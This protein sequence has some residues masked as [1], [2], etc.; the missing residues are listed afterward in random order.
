[1]NPEDD[2]GTWSEILLSCIEMNAQLHDVLPS[3]NRLLE[4]ILTTGYLN[5][6]ITES[7]EYF[8]KTVLKTAIH[9]LLG[10]DV[11]DYDAKGDIQQ[12][13]LNFT[14]LFTWAAIQGDLDLV[15]SAQQ[16]F[17]PKCNI[18]RTKNYY[19]AY[20]MDAK[21]MMQAWA[22]SDDPVNLVIHASSLKGADLLNVLDIIYRTYYGFAFYINID[23][24][25]MLGTVPSLK[26]YIASLTDD[27]LN[28]I[29]LSKLWIVV[30]N[31]VQALYELDCEGA[32]ITGLLLDFGERLVESDIRRRQ[33]IGGQI[34][35]LVYTN[36]LSDTLAV[37]QEWK[38]RTKLGTVLIEMEMHPQLLEAVDKFLPDLLDEKTLG[39]FMEKAENSHTSEKARMFGIAS[40]AMVNLSSDAMKAFVDKIRAKE[41]ISKEMI[42]FLASSLSFVSSKRSEIVDDILDTLIEFSKDKQKEDAVLA[43]F[44][45]IGEGRSTVV[46]K[47]AIAK[48][49]E[50]LNNKETTLF[51]ASALWATLRY[52]FCTDLGI[53]LPDVVATAIRDTKASGQAR[54]AQFQLM[55]M[56]VQKSYEAVPPKVIQTIVESGSDDAVWMF[57]GKLL[58]HSGTDAL[59]SGTTKIIVQQI[60]ANGLANATVPF[61]EFLKTFILTLNLRKGFLQNTYGQTTYKQKVVTTQFEITQWPIRNSTLLSDCVVKCESAEVY[62]KAKEALVFMCSKVRSSERPAV[63]E[64]FIQAF[65]DAASVGDN[66]KARVLSTLIAYIDKIEEKVHLEDFG[67]FRHKSQRTTGLWTLHIECQAEGI[68]Y[69][70]Q[71]DPKSS[72]YSLKERICSK[73]GYLPSNVT[74]M[75]DRWSISQYHTLELAYVRN[76]SVISVS[77]IRHCERAP[78]II[79]SLV[80]HERGFTSEVYKELETTK[81]QALYKECKR[82]LNRLPSNPKVIESLDDMESVIERMRTSSDY[83]FEYYLR[84]LLASLREDSVYGEKFHE[85]GGCPVLIQYLLNHSTEPKL[86]DQV[87]IAVETLFCDDMV[88]KAEDVIPVL[89]GLFPLMKESVVILSHILRLFG[90]HDALTTTSVTMKHFEP[91]AKAIEC[92]TRE[93]YSHFYYYMQSIHEKYQ[94]SLLCLKH[95]KSSHQQERNYFHSLFVS[96]IMAVTDEEQLKDILLECIESLPQ[97][98]GLVLGS[99]CHVVSSLVSTHASLQQQCHGIGKAILPSIF[100]TSDRKVRVEVCNLCTELDVW[101]DEDCV[102]FMRGALDVSIDRWNYDPSKKKVSVPGYVGLRNLG[103]TCY[104]NSVLQQLFYTY[105]FRYL[106]VTTEVTDESQIELKRIFTELLLSTRYYCD[107]KPFCNVWKGWMKRPINPREQQDAN[108]FFQLLLD[109]LPAD[110]HSMFKGEIENRIEGTDEEFVSTNLETFYSIGLDIKDLSSVT[111]SFGSFVQNEYFTGENQYSIGDRKINARK[112]ARIKTAPNVLVLQL[113]RFEYD[114]TTFSRRK[115]DDKYEFE[116]EFNLQ[117]YMVDTSQPQIY[118]LSGVV[119]HSGNAEGGHYCSYVLIGNEWLCFDDS[120]VSVVS[121]YDF[122]DDTYGGSDYYNKDSLPGSAYLLFYRKKDA[123]VQ[124][125]GQTLSFTSPP[126]LSGKCNPVMAREIEDANMEFTKHQALF[127]AK[128]ASFVCGSDD[129]VVLLEYFFNVFCHS[130]LETRAETISGHLMNLF[131]N[132]DVMTVFNFVLD[133]YVSIE[134]IFRY[135]GSPGILRVFHG[136]IDK[137]LELVDTENGFKLLEKFVDM[138]PPLVTANWKQ[139]PN[140]TERLYAAFVAQPAYVQLASQNQWDT[141]LCQL[142][143]Q[144]YD[145]QKSSVVL[146]NI[147]LSTVFKCLCLVIENS[148]SK[149]TLSLAPYYQQIFQSKLHVEA[150][151]SLLKLLHKGNILELAEPLDLLMSIESYQ[152]MACDLLLNAFASKSAD[153]SVI[154]LL[155]KVFQRNYESSLANFLTKS[156]VLVTNGALS[157]EVINSLIECRGDLIF[158]FLSDE[159]IQLAKA[160]ESLALSLIPN[161]PPA[162]LDSSVEILK[163]V[164]SDTEEYSSYRMMVID[165]TRYVS[166]LRV[167]EASIRAIEHIDEDVFKVIMDFGTLV[168]E[169]RTSCDDS[170]L[171]QCVSTVCSVPPSLL[172]PKFPEVFHWAFAE[173]DGMFSLSLPQTFAAFEHAI[174]LL[175]KAT[176][177]SIIHSDV[178]P[179]LCEQLLT[180]V[181]EYSTIF[182]VFTNK[183]LEESKDTQIA[184]VLVNIFQI[185]WRNQS[186]TSVFPS[187][188]RSLVNYSLLS[189]NACE[190]FLSDFLETLPCSGYY[191]VS[192]AKLSSYCRVACEILDSPAMSSCDSF[193]FPDKFELK[194]FIDHYA[195]LGT[196]YE[197]AT[198]MS[199][200]LVKLVKYVPVE[201][202]QKLYKDVWEASDIQYSLIFIILLLSLI[203]CTD[204]CIDDRFSEISKVRRWF[205]NDMNKFMEYLDQ[206]TNKSS[207]VEEWEKQYLILMAEQ[208]R[209]YVD[210]V[211][212]F[213][214]RVVESLTDGEAITFM[215]IFTVDALAQYFEWEIVSKV[216]TKH[217]AIRSELLSLLPPFAEVRVHEPKTSAFVNSVYGSH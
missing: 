186:S 195:S 89:L 30:N 183:L 109:Q 135:C 100:R 75:A 116:R 194:Q 94:L 16:V 200:F 50:Q 102:S 87:L 113:K 98:S 152:S 54:E 64:Y 187:F 197:T 6:P 14:K 66:A 216:F 150:F 55:N 130:N 115:V 101:A 38:E 170:V 193:D 153:I 211:F 161:D 104:M 9:G 210:C 84:I 67:F 92:V 13:L 35:S 209:Y 205:A 68:S 108:E 118:E 174:P 139:L 20:D 177:L 202:A 8:L 2:F 181:D 141:K 204:V 10:L 22:E 52:D 37:W 162:F 132:H 45:E 199:L 169:T 215:R 142:I 179:Y 7:T 159:S 72:P 208:D 140:I 105:P 120:E 154:E 26:E 17:S 122:E 71:A 5:S 41:K 25:P 192:N 42:E 171:L 160:A 90:E 126:E 133:H 23:A 79:P 65:T 107:T 129:V 151:V 119:V 36:T 91:L 43:G 168:F 83:I 88:S 93:A 97:V 49:I 117:E 73:L 173:Y 217:V 190:Q 33:I 138:L 53:D 157:S 163:T 182:S 60:E 62:Q 155:K 191:G 48:C 1:M 213:V 44:K 164:L 134:P 148:S 203:T 167:L 103:S 82:L 123:V 137:L 63:I 131:A 144:V 39:V 74:L 27:D 76:G 59:V 19:S 11:I 57:L 96:L 136:F 145:S 124:V 15:K 46:R 24:G 61:V 12:A 180:E 86:L 214:D 127:S 95:M 172:L 99:L 21:T 56:L 178:Y 69:D 184:D 29:D 188:V 175:D 121:E 149:T 147:D 156:K 165:D 201:Y 18:Y 78:V 85:S 31:L 196:D 3:F 34:I 110:F 51:G 198:S 143:Q 158:P 207:V 77:V 166:L 111:E 47:K 4:T 206:L 106:I 128:M 32:G 189:T 146:Q 81:D 80:L 28:S 176:L 212:P 40:K 125:E 112:F 70:I 114:L 185:W 58:K